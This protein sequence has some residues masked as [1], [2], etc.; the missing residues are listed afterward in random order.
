MLL[1]L[2]HHHLFGRPDRRVGR[3]LKWPGLHDPREYLRPHVER[4]MP[5]RLAFP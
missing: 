5:G 1:R 4:R 3:E 2:D